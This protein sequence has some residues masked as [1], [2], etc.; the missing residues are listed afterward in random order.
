MFHLLD[1]SRSENAT[2]NYGLQGCRTNSQR[3]RTKV[4]KKGHIQMK[5]T[6]FLTSTM[7]N[8]NK[9]FFAILEALKRLFLHIS[10]AFFTKLERVL[11]ILMQNSRT[12]APLA[13]K[14]PATLITVKCNLNETAINSKTLLK[15]KEEI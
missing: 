5:F 2:V 11:F 13:P 12:C 6:S 14:T 8:S 7:V 15:K 3:G 4:N 9:N 10:A 1:P